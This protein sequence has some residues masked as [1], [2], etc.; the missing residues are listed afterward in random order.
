MIIGAQAHDHAG[1]KIV[2]EGEGDAEAGEINARRREGDTKK[3]SST[4]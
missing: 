3:R 2:R 4:K 1:Y